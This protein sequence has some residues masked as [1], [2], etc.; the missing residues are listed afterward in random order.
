MQSARTARL[1]DLQSVVS[2]WDDAFADDPPNASLVDE[3]DGGIG[4]IEIRRL[5]ED[6]TGLVF[7]FEILEGRLPSI[8][9]RIA[10][11]IDAFL[12]AACL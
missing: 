12:C 3:D 1:I 4:V 8:G 6:G 9:D 10:V 11:T 2:T 5:T 7:E